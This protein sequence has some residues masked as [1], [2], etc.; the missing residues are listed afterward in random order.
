MQIDF[1]HAVTYALSRIA[2][3]RHSEAT[4][5]AYASQYVDDAKNQGLI[6]FRDG[7]TYDHIA[8]AHTVVPTSIREVGEF[9]DNLNN[10]LNAEAW[11]PFHF[12]PGNL[13][14]LV[15]DGREA[16]M[17]RRLVCTTDSPVAAEMCR[18][19][20]DNR[21]QANGLHRLGITTHVYADTW[22]HRDFVGLNHSFNRIHGLIH[23]QPGLHALKEDAQSKALAAMP[24]GH[25]MVLTLPDQPFLSW[26]FVDRDG[27]SN[28]R[29]NTE[30][31]IQAS[32]RII[33][34]H[35]SYRGIE[36]TPFMS[37]KDMETLQW[38]FATFDSE[39][40][41]ARHAEWMSLFSQERFSFGALSTQ[42]LLELNYAP[43]G[44]DSWK[45]KALKTDAEKDD[46]SDVF[47]S[48]PAFDSSDWK[49][50]HDALKDH[51]S[52]V[53]GV[54]LPKFGLNPSG[55]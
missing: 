23:D 41:D 13:G 33:A 8:S 24:I 11:L 15:G 22:V 4:I 17:V 53:M 37:A 27:N 46:P 29:K 6:Q 16:D 39:D 10:A 55:C 3:F 32:E 9:R 25:G 19:C 28:I 5:I 43:K 51:R 20:I 50:F 12:L 52:N 26:G 1:H 35:R 36:N 44:Q 31:F 49:L 14:K 34:F 30:I 38:A 21:N 42:E 2:G 54:I 40:G 48:N 18:D 7:R 47:E 45:Y